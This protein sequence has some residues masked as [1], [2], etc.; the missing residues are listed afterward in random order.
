MVKRKNATIRDVARK[1]GVSVATVSR[2]LNQATFVSEALSARIQAAMDALDYVPQAHA[3][4]LALR[5]HGAIGLLLT[6]MDQ[7]YFGP[8]LGGIEET[9]RRHGYNLLVATHR[10]GQPPPLGRHNTDGLLVF[11]DTLSDAELSQQHALGVPLVLIHRRPPPGCPIPH[12][13]IENK[14]ATQRL[15]EHLIT[16]HGRREIVFLGGPPDNEE[17]AQRAQGYAAALAAHGIAVDPARRLRGDFTQDTAYR[18]FTK[19]RRQPAPPPFDAVFAG[20]DAAA[21]GV[22]AALAEAGRRIPTDVAVVGF[23]DAPVAPFLTPP[24]TTVR[25]PTAAIGRSAAEQLF[26]LLAGDPAAPTIVHP[27]TLV[28]RR[29]CGCVA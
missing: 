5:R 18:A 20:S 29:S 4:Q 24:L 8:L 21:L 12:V 26:R 11:A 19:L 1:A 14:S 9:V 28:L 27:T 6:G 10:A 13:T 3:R 16:A 17:S 23:D 25:A 15:I 22:Y 7:P 2:Y